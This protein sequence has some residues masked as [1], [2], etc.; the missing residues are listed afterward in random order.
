MSITHNF[1]GNIQAPSCYE[2]TCIKNGETLA[3]AVMVSV[4]V[5][6]AMVQVLYLTIQVNLSI[7]YFFGWMV[8]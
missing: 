5:M 3:Q 1:P 2:N 6:S 8:W 4:W 7:I